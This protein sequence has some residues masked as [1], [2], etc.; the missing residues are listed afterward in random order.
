VLKK[1]CPP[2]KRKGGKGKIKKLRFLILRR[3]VDL[4]PRSSAFIRGFKLP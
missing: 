2:E 1:Y 4:N 3:H